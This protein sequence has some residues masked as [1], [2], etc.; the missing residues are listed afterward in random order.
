MRLVQSCDSVTIISLQRDEIL[1]QLRSAAQAIR[2]Q[3]PEVE[4]IRFFGS[5]ARREETGTSDVDILIIVARG[6]NLD[7][8]HQRIRTFLPYFHLPIGLD[9]LVYTQDELDRQL[10][11]P[12]SFL[13]TIWAESQPL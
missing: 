1:A 2:A 10:Q 9:L 5:L 8:P 3:H 11:D 4:S 13:H 6:P 7:D 12:R